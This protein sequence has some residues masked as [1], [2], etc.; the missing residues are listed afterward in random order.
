MIKSKQEEIKKRTL[1]K[2]LN[3][4]AGLKTA[5]EKEAY[6]SGCVSGMQVSRDMFSIITDDVFGTDSSNLTEKL[7]VDDLKFFDN[8][9]NK[10]KG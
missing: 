8:V 9:I 3:E 7:D 1:D 4:C 10:V 5:K 6:I 2:L